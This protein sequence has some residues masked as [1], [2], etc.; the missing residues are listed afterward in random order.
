MFD[1]LR[2]MYNR[3]QPAFFSAATGDF[4]TIGVWYD[5]PVNYSKITDDIYVGTT[6][7]PEDYE[8]LKSLNVELVINMRVEKRPHRDPGEDP[9][10]VLWLRTFDTPLIWIPVRTLVRGVK[11]ALK[12]IELG[13]GVYIH[14]AAGVHRSVAMASCLLIAQG[15]SLEEA[16]ELIKE[17]RP[18]ADPDAWYIFRQIRKF[19]ARWNR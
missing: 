15:F 6:P 13:G 5:H 12:V 14:C 3:I 18:K 7:E 1:F 10:P 16:V 2:G 19:E 17:K 9:M 8:H 4:L 11:E